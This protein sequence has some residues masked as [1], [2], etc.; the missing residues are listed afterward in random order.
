MSGSLTR[1]ASRAWRRWH[2]ET[3]KTDARVLAILSHREL[4]P[5]IWLPDPRVRAEHEQARFRL[6][7]VK[8]KGMLKHRIHATMMSFRHPCPVSD[9]SA[10]RRPRAG[11][12]PRDP[13]AV[14]IDNRREPLH[15]R[16]PRGRDRFDRA[17]A[18]RRRGWPPARAAAV[19]GPRDRARAGVHDRRGDRRHHTVPTA[20]K[21][22]G[23]P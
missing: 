2:C 17:P 4:I 6:H 14:A 7:L 15:D 22:V 20:K 16:L 10:H 21:L 19:D 11:G 1:T 18:T 13:A 5:E 3:D 12:P 8:H 23:T 9:C